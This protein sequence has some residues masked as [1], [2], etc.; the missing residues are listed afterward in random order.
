MCSHSDDPALMEGYT[1]CTINHDVRRLHRAYVSL[2]P[3]LTFDH[4]DRRAEKIPGY[5]FYV[6]YPRTLDGRQWYLALIFIEAGT[7]TAALL[8]PEESAEAERGVE[9]HL[10]GAVTE[11]F[12]AYVLQ[13]MAEL[14]EGIPYKRPLFRLTHTASS[15]GSK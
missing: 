10:K 3:Y 15:L 7:R 13:V 6:P 4:I 1:R 9:L 8:L 2:S 11:S 14:L 12:C 5:G